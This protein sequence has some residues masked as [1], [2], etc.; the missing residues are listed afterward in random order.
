MKI[1]ITGTS[2]G[3]GQNLARYL[4]AAGHEIW[5]LA[6]RPHDEFLRECQAR[7][8]AFRKSRCDISSWDQVRA[9]QEEVE[10]AWGFLD[11]LI[12]CAGIQGPLGPA[13]GLDPQ[14]WIESLA[15]NVNGTFFCL[16]A[17]HDLLRRSPRRAKVVCFSGGGSTGPRIN[18]TPYAVAKAGLVRL[19]ENLAH[20]WKNQPIDINAIAPGAVNTRMTEEVLALGPEV[21]GDKEFQ[22]ATAQWKEGGTPLETYARCVAFLI[23]QESD[24]LSGRLIAAKWDPWPQFPALTREIQGSDLLTLRRITPEDRGKKW[25]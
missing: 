5:G 7:G 6:R 14:R 24:G 19:V 21:V 18:F 17:F 13:M 12:C 10:K 16:R 11:A 20:E 2:S 4:G 9:C 1:L 8:V 3:I 23:S 15:I 25:P 22:A